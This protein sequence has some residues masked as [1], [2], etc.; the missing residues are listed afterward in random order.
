MVSFAFDR[1]FG[2]CGAAERGTPGVLR[3]AANL[4]AE[5]FRPGER[6]CLQFT[7]LHEKI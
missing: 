6:K 1:S 3:A 7:G 2:G 4:S 5:N